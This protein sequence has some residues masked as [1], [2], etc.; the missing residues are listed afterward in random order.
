MIR[1]LAAD[2]ACQLLRVS[3]LWEVQCHL[4]D[5]EEIYPGALAPRPFCQGHGL[6]E[7]GDD[8]AEGRIYLERDSLTHYKEVNNP[9]TRRWQD[10]WKGIDT[11]TKIH[12]KTVR[13]EDWTYG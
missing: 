4:R 13:I 7:L 6:A 8:F 5:D 10:P 1:G 9:C 3:N 12:N 2:L 11:K